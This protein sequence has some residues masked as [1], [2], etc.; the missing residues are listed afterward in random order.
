MMEDF[1]MEGMFEV[2]IERLRRD[3]RKAMPLGPRFL[4]WRIV[5]P[6]GP[7]DVEL[8]DFDMAAWTCSEVKG[9]KEESRGCF[10]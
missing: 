9:V 5:R 4:R 3:V 2:L 10:L 1:Q 8:G 6:S 7:I